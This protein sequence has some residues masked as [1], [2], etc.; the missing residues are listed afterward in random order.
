MERQIIQRRNREEDFRQ[1]WEHNSRSFSKS[2]M[3]ANKLEA[4]SSPQ[5]YMDRHVAGG[6]EKWEG[7]ALFSAIRSL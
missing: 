6:T 3:R 1:T 2:D 7:G 4:W 5:S